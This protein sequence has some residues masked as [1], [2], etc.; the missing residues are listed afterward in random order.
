MTNPIVSTHPLVAHKL[1]L[2]RSVQTEP[3]KFRELTRE[4]GGLLRVRRES[5]SGHLFY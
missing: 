4:L 5:V 1:S 3:K 2:L